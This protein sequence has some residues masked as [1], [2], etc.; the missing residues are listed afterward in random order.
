MAGGLCGVAT[1]SERGPGWWH[2]QVVWGVVLGAAGLF[3][4]LERG[5]NH[6]RRLC[7]RIGAA[8]GNR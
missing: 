7:T 1:A 3:G 4:A 2:L 6:A 8:L 5:S